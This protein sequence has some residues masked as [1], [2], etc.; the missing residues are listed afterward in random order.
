MDALSA[1]HHRVIKPTEV[2]AGDASHSEL[3]TNEW[4]SQLT[5]TLDG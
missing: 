5:F 1:K 4:W 2:L 3:A